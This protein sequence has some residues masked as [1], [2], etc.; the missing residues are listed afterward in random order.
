MSLKLDKIN[1]IKVKPL[2]IEE[3]D[4]KKIL[5]GDLFTLN[6][7]I[8][9]YAPKN[10]GKT[11]TINTIIE[12]CADKDTKI[13]IFCETINSDKTWKEII[14]RLKKSKMDYIAYTSIFDDN[15]VNRIDVLR[16]MLKEE[17]REME[18]D[19]KPNKKITKK[20]LKL[21]FGENQDETEA[22]KKRKKKY[23]SSAYL[24]IFDDISTELK[25]PSIVRFMKIQR[26]FSSKI[27]ISSQSWIDTNPNIRKGNLDYVLLF[28]NIP[29]EVL[30]KIH[31]ELAI[32][33]KL[34]L[35]IKMY[36]HAT[37]EKYHF[38]YID[39]NDC[40]RKDFDGQYTLV[41]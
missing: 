23:E 19:G 41:A 4:N 10:S 9:I 16:E 22:K 32:P 34:K 13:I 29:D 2:K 21:M 25:D 3:A 15:G 27:I 40:Y 7:N 6:A 37:Q 14:N 24:V 30:E 33:M 31:S 36:C 38:L 17:A 1:D 28:K 18:D 35:F 8:F 5:G 26:H 12:E 20:K 11:V 39:K